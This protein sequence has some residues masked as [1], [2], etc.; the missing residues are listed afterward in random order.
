MKRTPDHAVLR[1]A[2]S[3]AAR[4]ERFRR[5]LV[6]VSAPAACAGR[7]V[8]VAEAG[9]PAA[10]ETL[11]ANGD[12]A[13]ATLTLPMPS[14]G[15]PYGPLAVRVEGQEPIV[16]ELPDADTVRK[17]TFH[18]MKLGFHAKVPSVWLNESVFFGDAFPLCEFQQPNLVEDLIGRYSL[19]PRFFDAGYR[20]V[21]A[22]SQPGRYGAIIDVRTEDGEVYRWYATLF[23]LPHRLRWEW[24]PTPAPGARLNGEVTIPVEM[25]IDPAVIRKHNRALRETLADL[26]WYGVRGDTNLT[27]TLLGLYEMGQAPLPEWQDNPKY[28]DSVWWYR[29]RRQVEGLKYAHLLA[30]PPDY[31]RLPER[32]WPLLVFLHGASESGDDLERVKVH[33][34]PRLIAEGRTFPFLVLSPQCPRPNG[35]LPEQLLDL[36]EAIC[37]TY[38]VDTDRIY[39]TGFS[40]GGHGTWNTAITYPDRFA[41]IAPICGT[42]DNNLGLS[43]IRHVPVWAFQG[44]RDPACSPTVH[45]A[46]VDAL[47]AAGGNVRYTLYPDADHDSWTRT[48][49]DPQFYEWLLSHQ[50]SSL[51]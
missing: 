22:P 40:M 37:A 32:R 47:Q 42:P 30:L 28:R 18:W 8:Q 4:Y 41:A 6:E 43:R 14:R 15:K 11:R 25:G 26:V 2:V 33:G 49:D 9:R 17:E 20:E 36:L 51:P 35:W 31:E 44:A 13:T 19:S 1:S 23:R 46:T 48:Y 27:V 5:V 29:L 24:G 16:V 38:R 39:L 45:Q 50:R 12:Q 21:A 3:V 34:P 7:A 10:T